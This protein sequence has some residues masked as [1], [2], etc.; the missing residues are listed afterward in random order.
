MFDLCLYCL[1]KF[2]TYSNRID[3]DM[4]FMLI[5]F[6]YFFPISY[7]T[8]HHELMLEADMFVMFIFFVHYIFTFH[9][10]HVAIDRYRHVC[11][12]IC[13]FFSILH[14]IYYMSSWID[15]DMFVMLLFLSLNFYISYI[16]SRYGS[17]PTCLLCF[18]FF[19]F[20]HFY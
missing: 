18:F 4:F 20:W 15:T 12:V 11:Y 14:F 3:T 1:L 7:F 19:F 9:I 6:H 17:I 13:F 10:L 5:I 16:A 8:C 2:F